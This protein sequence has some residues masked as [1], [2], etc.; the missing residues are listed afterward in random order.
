MAVP[1][2][3]SRAHSSA[4]KVAIEPP[5]VNSPRAV[6]GNPI[7][8]RSQS[9]AFDSSCTSAGPAIHTPVKRFV[10]ALMKSARAAGNVPPPGM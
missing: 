4:L 7:Q 3:F 10:V 5:V 8:S 9:S 1:R 6:G 2:C